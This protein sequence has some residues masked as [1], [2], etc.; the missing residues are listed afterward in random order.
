MRRRF[1]WC[2]LLFPVLLGSGTAQK[3][4]ER[5]PGHHHKRSV[6]EWLER[7]ES[8]SRADW[9][10]PDDVVRALDLQA[11]DAV[12]DVGAGSGYFS[13]RF[14]RSV[15][16]KGK[17][18]AVD[19]DRGL[20]E[21]LRERA[22]KERLG[23]LE[24]VLAAPDDPKLA[25]RSADM[26]FL[27]NVAHHIENRSGYYKKIAAALRPGGRV[28]V[29]EFFKRE[30]PVGPDA[31]MKIARE[32][33]IREFGESGFQLQQEFDFLPYQYFLVFAVRR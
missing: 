31:A 11:G 22:S 19:I 18:F 25:P 12:A 28:A 21:Y 15:G 33:V 27:C 6:A 9:Q 10:K 1:P 2:G 17:V 16:E 20:V 26:I 29:V 14:A 24:A 8:P 23:N 13:T 7:L 32:N 3:H 30:L 4:D 5:P